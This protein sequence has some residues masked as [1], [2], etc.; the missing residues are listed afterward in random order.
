MNTS[1]H[2]PRWLDA[3]DTAAYIGKRVEQLPRLVKDGKLPEPSR[4]LGPKQP[5]WDRL[6]IDR[7]FEGDSHGE[8]VETILTQLEQQARSVSGQEGARGRQ[9]QNLRIHAPA[10]R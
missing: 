3:D 2:E 10:K 6:A 8:S 7:L 9:R 5:R 1:L 4:H